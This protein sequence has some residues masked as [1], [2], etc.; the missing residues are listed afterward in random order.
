MS[1][2]L[3][4][5]KIITRGG[6]QVEVILSY[7]EWRRIVAQFSKA[8]AAMPMKTPTIL[9][10]SP[11]RGWWMPNSPL[12]CPQSAGARSRP[13]FRCTWSEPRSKELTR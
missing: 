2:A 10:R 7:A 6:E 1:F 11:Q 9:P 4:K 5:P 8:G 12:E 3:P 13:R